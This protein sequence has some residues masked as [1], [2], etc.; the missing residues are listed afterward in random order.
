MQVKGFAKLTTKGQITLPKDVR[1][2][3][4]LEQGD[5]MVFLEDEDG[6]IYITKEVEM[7]RPKKK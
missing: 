2:I 3:L 7:V 4:K 6:L 5:Y 1:T